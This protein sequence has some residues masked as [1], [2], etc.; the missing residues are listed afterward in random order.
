[1]ATRRSIR[2]FASTSRALTVRSQQPVIQAARHASSAVQ[3]STSGSNPQMSFPCV[4]ANELRAQRIAQEKGLRDAKG[5][6]GA[7]A[8]LA[9]ESLE[10]ASS[11]ANV[12]NSGPGEAKLLYTSY[13]EQSTDCIVSHGLR[14]GLQQDRLWLQD[15][16]PLRAFRARLRRSAATIRHSV[17][18]VG[19]AQ[20]SERQCDPAPHRTV[21]FLS[22]ALNTGEP[23]RRVVGE[24]HRP[25]QGYR[26]EPVL[27]HLYECPG[28]LLRLDWT[29][30]HRPL[31]R[32]AVCYAL[33]HIEHL[34]HGASAVSPPRLAGRRQAVCECGQQYGRNAECRGGASAPGEG[35]EGGQHQRECEE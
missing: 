25:E 30:V 15:I 14:T 23:S 21:S 10:Q 2:T 4:D 6:G 20:R 35:R 19:D 18:D 1:M 22:C 31:R 27:R 29:V 7:A 32:A 13:V 5:K 3:Q 24:V 11:A 28:R 9:A 26:H 33:S 12:D 17:R 34:R 16:S 8:A